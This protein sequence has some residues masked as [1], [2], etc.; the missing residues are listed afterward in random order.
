MDDDMNSRGPRKNTSWRKGC[1]AFLAFSILLLAHL[2]EA[3]AHRVSVFAWVEDD[4]VHV[5][6]KFAGGKHVK[7]GEI[8]VYDLQGQE[9]LRGKPDENGTFAFKP[10]RWVPMRIVLQAG[11]GHRG[12]W[13]IG[14]EDLANAKGPVLERMLEKENLPEERTKSLAALQSN[15]GLTPEEIALLVGDVMDAKLKPV[16]AALREMRDS[17]TSLKDVLG[18]IGYILGIVGVASY[19]HFRRKSVDR[20]RIKQ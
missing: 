1:F 12:E 20:D 3:G 19:F 10:D 8:I 16:L 2:G 13:T 18:G 5:E 4:M 17:G 15:T 11:M 14:A 7:S 6:G 9:M